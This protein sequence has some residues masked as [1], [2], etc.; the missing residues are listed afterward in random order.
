M[1]QL[2]CFI[3]LTILFF[4]LLFIL[5]QTPQRILAVAL[6]Y[7]L[8]C[9]VCMSVYYDAANRTRTQIQRV[10]RTLAQVQDIS[11]G[12]LSYN[13]TKLESLQK[14]VQARKNETNNKIDWREAITRDIFKLKGQELN[15]DDYRTL[16]GNKVCI[17]FFSPFFITVFHQVV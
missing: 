16:V 2:Y 7:T 4:C 11:R 15:V 8:T 5:F 12:V 1:Y 9:L 10:N 14:A 13:T 3:I 17:H 6:F